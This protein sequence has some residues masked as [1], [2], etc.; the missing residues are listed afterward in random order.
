[1]VGFFFISL[2]LQL[3]L[4]WTSSK[5]LSKFRLMLLFRELPLH[6]LNKTI[7]FWLP[8]EMNNPLQEVRVIVMVNLSQMFIVNFSFNKVAGCSYWNEIPTFSLNIVNFFKAALPQTK[9]KCIQL[10]FICFPTH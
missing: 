7:F 2:R 5:I 3:N 8:K 1:M 10:N 6:S 4:E 9:C